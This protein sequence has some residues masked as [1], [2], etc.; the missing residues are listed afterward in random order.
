MPEEKK[1]RFVVEAQDSGHW[2][3]TNESRI[4][5]LGRQETLMAVMKVM[6]SEEEILEVI[7][8]KKPRHSLEIEDEKRIASAIHALLTEKLK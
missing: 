2:I 8:Y 5:N 3:E 4:Y 6:P 7:S 1:G